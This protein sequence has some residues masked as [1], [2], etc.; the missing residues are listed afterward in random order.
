[1]AEDTDEDGYP[2]CIDFCPDIVSEDN[3]DSDGDGIG[4][5]CDNC[6]LIAN[7]KQEDSDGDGIGD[8]CDCIDEDD[9]GICDPDPTCKDGVF[10]PTVEECEP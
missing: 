6:P 9:D 7:D 1:L 4:D 3:L 10:D 5:V 8:A 2:D